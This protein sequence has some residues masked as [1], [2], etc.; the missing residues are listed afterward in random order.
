MG[1]ILDMDYIYS[2]LND[3]VASREMHG[4]ETNT[5]VVTVNAA[6]NTIS[7]DVKPISPSMLNVTKPTEHGSYILQETISEIGEV[8]YSWATLEEY[9]QE[10]TQAIANL[11]Q[12]L[13][14]EKQERIESVQAEA[15]TRELADT[16]LH[17]EFTSEIAEEA[18]R[19]DSMINQLNDN[20]QEGFNTINNVLTTSI[21]SINNAILNESTIREKQYQD[22]EFRI[23][24]LNTRLGVEIDN[25]ESGDAEIYAN[26]ST[27]IANEKRE[28]VEQDQDIRNSISAEANSRQEA[29]EELS[30]RITSEA[31]RTDSMINQLN[32]NVQEGFNILNTVITDSINTI[33]GGIEEERQTRVT[34]DETLQSNIDA[35]ANERKSVDQHLWDILPDNIIAG[36]PMQG[37]E[38]ANAINIVFSKYQKHGIGEDPSDA[39]LVEVPNQAITLFPA[40]QEVAG[41]LTAADKTKIDNIA[42]DIETAVQAE[43]NAREEADNALSERIT[44]IEDTNVLQS[45]ILGD[46]RIQTTINSPAGRTFDVDIVDISN[47][48]NDDRFTVTLNNNDSISAM[49]NDGTTSV[50]LVFMSKWNKVEVGGSGAPLNLNSDDSHVTVNDTYT[51]LDNRDKDEINDTISAETERA[52]QVEAT[53]NGRIDSVIINASH[54]LVDSVSVNIASENTATLDYTTYIPGTGIAGESASV[55]IPMATNTAAG[56]MSGTHVK[57]IDN[58]VKKNGVAEQTINGTLNVSGNVTIGGNLHVQGNT[59]TVDTETINV[60]DNLI[61]TNSDGVKLEYPSGIAIKT[62]ST[63]AFGIVF[64]P[65]AD[66]LKAGIGSLDENN[67]FL[68]DGEEGNP[69]ALRSSDTEME[70]NAITMWDNSYKKIVTTNIPYTS[71]ARTDKSQTFSGTQTFSSAPI[72]PSLNIGGFSI[73]ATSSGNIATQE[74]LNSSIDDVNQAISNI[75]GGG[76]CFA[77]LVQIEQDLSNI[78]SSIASINVGICGINANINSINDN[79]DGLEA[80]ITAETQ[81]ATQAEQELQ[82]AISNVSTSLNRVELITTDSSPIGTVFG[83]NTA[84]IT[85]PMGP[86]GPTGPIPTITVGEVTTGEAGSQANVSVNET[87]SGAEF[88]FTIPVGEN[89]YTYIP[90]I[91]EN[92]IISWSRTQGSGTVPPSTNII[93]PIGPTGPTG[94]AGTG[95][96]INGDYDSEEELESAH[97]TGT[98]GEAYLVNG[99]LYVWSSTSN[100]WVSVGAIQ[101]PTGPTGAIGAAANI[102]GATATISGNYGTPSVTVTS[103]GTDQARTFAFAFSNLRGATGASAGFGTPTVSTTTGNPGTNASV[104]VTSSG[105]N[106]ERIFNFDFTIP[107]GATGP[108][109][110]TGPAGGVTSVVIESPTGKGVSIVD[111]QINTSGGIVTIT[112]VRGPIDD[113][114]LQI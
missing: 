37:M 16:Q 85:I 106:T 77:N 27:D 9:N 67:E 103:G 79:I 33:N 4:S 80:N 104:S 18:R 3:D 86:T 110:A 72:V 6:T 21:N 50:P 17:I 43:A 58:S 113:G 97:P 98:P 74:Q 63:S 51:L 101:G 102:T 15:N 99:V 22:T 81:R 93:G 42:T 32:N 60:T 59:V 108:T 87:S 41:V 11:T 95:V 38:N 62:N 71:V 54:S 65:D 26:L 30:N 35:E 107:R 114:E 57:D 109:G 111:L 24:D 82:E 91:D 48:S 52:T 28:R 19:T 55:T 70:E 20:V 105:T 23:R 83:P 76:G 14:Q 89:G 7:V 112:P 45:Q 53:I 31:N 100:S 39:E 1:E 5:A 2:C 10:V 46:G 25:R 44:A 88:S 92:G 47:A 75:T 90:S 13:E 49:L 34:A 61:V 73:N 36:T 94:P 69:I 56:F 12:Q 64:D 68:F 8:S 29:F 84:T 66:E 78:N 40:T 96:Q